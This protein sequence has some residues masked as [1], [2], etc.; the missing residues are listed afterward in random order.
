MSLSPQLFSILSAIASAFEKKFAA[1]WASL[2]FDSIRATVANAPDLDP[3]LSILSAATMA[4]E[5]DFSAPRKSPPLTCAS[6]IF[7]NAKY[8]NQVRLILSAVDMASRNLPT[9]ACAEAISW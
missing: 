4:L 6:A 1:F 7:M 5:L 8:F 9:L 3:S 2:T